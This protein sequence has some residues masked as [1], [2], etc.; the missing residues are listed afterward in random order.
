MDI[1][2]T[3]K[4]KNKGGGGGGGRGEEREGRD[5]SMNQ[6]FRLTHD[7][8]NWWNSSKQDG[9]PEVVP[10]DRSIYG[11]NNGRTEDLVWINTQNLFDNYICKLT[12]TL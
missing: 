2:S 11:Q 9:F 3:L 8:G 10:H 12:Y 4:R 6:I 7:G 5:F 1:L